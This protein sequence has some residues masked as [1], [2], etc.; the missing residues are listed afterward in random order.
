MDMYLL[1]ENIVNLSAIN[2][3]A[4][5]LQETSNAEITLDVLRLDKIDPVISGNKWFKLKYY[6]ETALENRQ[7]TLLTFGGAYSNH[8]IATACAAQKMG[9]GSI[10]IIR[11]GQPASLSHTLQEAAGLGM[12]L[13]FTSREE[14]NHKTDPAFIEALRRQF[15][16][17]CIIPEG[18]EGQPGVKGAAEIIL[19]T[20]IKKYTHVCCAIGTG[21]VL[22]GLAR[23]LT[24]HQH[25]LG[26]AVLKGFDNWIPPRMTTA[27]QQRTQI[28]TAYHFG[29][30]AKKTPDLIAFMN[31]W[32]SSTLIP[33]DFVYTGKMFYGLFDLIKKGYFPATSRVLAIHSGGLQGN[34]SLPPKTLLF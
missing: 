27:E 12:Q 24:P 15:N 4:V 23:G 34:H 9:L 25:L 26:I 3:D 10:G 13:V 18:G 14:Y 5:T 8:I 16:D 1:P 31:Q 6:L 7:Q 19:Y 22:S 20:D 11:G 30:Y 32:Y 2:T 33:S 21:T 29:G 28:I 17:P